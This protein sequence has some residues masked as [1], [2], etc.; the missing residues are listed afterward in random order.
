MSS[1]TAL[2]AAAS[3]DA[4]QMGSQADEALRQV[5]TAA[6]TRRIRLLDSPGASLTVVCPDWCEAD[7]DEDQTHG[8][9]LA[10]FAHLGRYEGL[11]L[12]G[13]ADTEEEVLFTEITQYP[14]RESNR[15][16]VIKTWPV[17]GGHGVTEMDPAAVCELAERLRQYAAVLDAKS[18]KVLGLRQQ[19][20]VEGRAEH[21]G[22]WAQ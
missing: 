21:E 4:P 14:F 5:R 6:R 20:K 17:L 16:P 11:D 2:Q 22:R 13:L 8:T 15:S 19:A 3:G 18:D 9:Y 12:T 7:H 1:R 10:D